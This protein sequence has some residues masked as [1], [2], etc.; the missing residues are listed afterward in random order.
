MR[1][2]NIF[3]HKLVKQFVNK[4]L[5]WYAFPNLVLNSVI[6]YFN[7]ENTSA[8]TLF[9]GEFCFARFILPMALFIPFAITV[10]CMKKTSIFITMMEENNLTPQDLPKNPSFFKYG[11]YNG[12]LTF[13]SISVMMCTLQWSIPSDYV[14]NGLVL[15]ILNGVLACLLAIYFTRWSI[16]K[17]RVTRSKKS[18][19]Y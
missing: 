4:K 12:L 6:P 10:D 16:R 13:L 1:N 2:D 8:V 15:S 17:L 18:F 9:R 5:F 7:F 19:F 14:F 3:T 11:I